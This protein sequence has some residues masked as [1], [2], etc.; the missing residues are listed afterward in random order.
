MRFQEERKGERICVNLMRGGL[1]VKRLKVVF[2]EDCVGC[3]KYESARS[4]DG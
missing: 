1:C 3:E 2:A 4:D